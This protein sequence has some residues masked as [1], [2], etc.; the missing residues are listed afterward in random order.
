MTLRTK[1]SES[2]I[3]AAA[4]EAALFPLRVSPGYS[5]RG[6]EGQQ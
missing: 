4:D 6:V 2:V 3:Y 5:R 1:G